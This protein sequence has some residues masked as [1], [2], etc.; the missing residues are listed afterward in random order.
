MTLSEERLRELHRSY[1]NIPPSVADMRTVDTATALA[2]LLSLRSDAHTSGEVKP[3]LHRAAS[4]LLNQLWQGVYSGSKTFDENWTEMERRYPASKWLQ[5]ELTALSLGHPIQGEASYW[6]IERTGYEGK[7]YPHWYVEDATGWHGWTPIAVDAKA[8]ATV[9]EASAF[10]AYRMIAT[11][12]SIKLTE[13]V[14]IAS[15]QPPTP[16]GVRE[17]TEEDTTK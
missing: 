5:D 7:P 9:Q 2:E 14:N 15:P 13:H 1:D 17:I 3:D 6:L 4:S 8:F 16:A 11:D 10:P 12:P